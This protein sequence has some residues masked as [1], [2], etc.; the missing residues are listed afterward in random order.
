MNYF[1]V[2]TLLISSAAWGLEADVRVVPMQVYHHQQARIEV[3]VTHE[4]R[5]KPTV[6]FPVFEGFWVETFP[7]HATEP[8]YDTSK[9]M[10]RTTVFRR[11]L[12]P[13]RGGKLELPR[14]ELRY[15]DADGMEVQQPLDPPR[16]TVLPLPKEGRPATFRGIV[17][18]PKLE[19]TVHETSVA[20][21]RSFRLRVEAHG[22]ANLWDLNFAGLETIFAGKAEV[23]P[24]K[25]RVVTGELD[26]RI[27][28]RKTFDFDLVPQSEGELAIPAL[29][30]PYF[31]PDDARYKIARSLP[32][33][34]QVVSASVAPA[35]TRNESATAAAKNLW[36]GWTWIA[37]AVGLL[38][39]VLLLR[40]WN[41]SDASRDG[42]RIPR[43]LFEKA[44]T[45][46]GSDEFSPLLIQT[47]K[48]EMFVRHGQ[49]V[50]A[51]STDE[52]AQQID[53]SAGVEL[54]TTL[55][56]IRFGGG[57]VNADEL[58]ASIKKYLGH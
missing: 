9:V 20:I 28:V 46:E 58:K 14:I 39:I 32:L 44:L 2:L 10:W 57:S 8:K 6:E 22:A 52:I 37:A 21:G 53:D 36:I 17:G 47:I 3:S 4:P 18:Q 51:L 24:V 13:T 35:T 43:L 56:R 41:R 30:L 23:F 42:R 45:V 54:L 34:V 40:W 26:G 50:E 48:A 38:T 49:S 31:D 55:D 11:G 19:T 5:E 12:F 16:L 15:T 29:V 1:A 33:T 7:I 27:T 25:P